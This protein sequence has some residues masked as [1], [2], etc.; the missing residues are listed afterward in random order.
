VHARRAR[1]AGNYEEVR[2]WVARWNSSLSLGW[3][4]DEIDDVTLHLNSLYYRYP[5]P[6]SA[7]KV[8]SLIQIKSATPGA[9]TLGR[10]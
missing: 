5:C 4:D 9:D 7:C 8:V 2:A 10:R 1:K 6:P 3:S